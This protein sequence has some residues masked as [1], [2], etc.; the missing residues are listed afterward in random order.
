MT[1]RLSVSDF[2]LQDF[3]LS[4]SPQDF[5]AK[6]EL[7]TNITAPLGSPD[8][9]QYSKELFSAPIPSAGIAVTGIFSVGAVISYEV[10]VSTSFSGSASMTFGV[11]ASL[12]NTAA[13][14]ADFRHPDQSSATGFDGGKF[15]PSFNLNALS[16][17]VTVAAFAQPKLS[18][19]IDIL[20]VGHLEIALGVKSP[21]VS[22]TL[23]GGY[24]KSFCPFP[25][26]AR[27][28]RT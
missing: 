2:K 16:A 12:P 21:V 5:A 28:M 11:A 19:G 3:T 26:Q 10:G 22:A 4:G 1:G 8:T 7:E 17:D 25:F 23:T 27:R 14:V 9:L 15:D 6:L 20:K 13:V 18:F 24:S